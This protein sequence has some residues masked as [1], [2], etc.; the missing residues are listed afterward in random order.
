MALSIIGDNVQCSSINVQWGNF[1]SE[2]IQMNRKQFV[3][4]LAVM[5]AMSLAGSFGAVYLLQGEP[6]QAAADSIVTGSE[7]R[8]VDGNGKL[9]TLI[10]VDKEGD[11]L[12][13]MLDAKENVRLSQTVGNDGSSA[14]LLNTAEGK[15]RMSLTSSGDQPGAFTVF[16]SK[17]EAAAVLAIG[18]DDFPLLTISRE[19]SSTILGINKGGKGL[20]A[21]SDSAGQYFTVT[22]GGDD[23]SSIMLNN[24]KAGTGIML[25]AVK[26]G[27]MQLA[28]KEKEELLAF[29]LAG[30]GNPTAL[31][32]DNEGSSV[33]L[34][35][36]DSGVS[37]MQLGV[38]DDYARVMRN[39]DGSCEYAIVKKKTY[40]WQQTG[41]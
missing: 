17:G 1:T 18:G 37:L 14:I 20:L 9:R 21:L 10:T 28:M 6:V 25:T 26:D 12:F 36:Q 38:G 3:I 19:G 4:A 7:F 27:L 39:K 15:P 11:V 35:A 31:E 32:L 16:D 5:G 2:R 22:G 29:L 30:G 23:P 33:K 41:K 24:N 40:A 13:T 34:Q 8:L